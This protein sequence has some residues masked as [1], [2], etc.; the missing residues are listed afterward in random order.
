MKIFIINN[1]YL[2]M[3]RQW[4]QMF[5]GK[6]YSQV[7]LEVQPD[8][9]RLAEAFGTVGLS[10]GE[11]GAPVSL[12]AF[13]SP[14]AGAAAEHRGRRAGRSGRSRWL[15]PRRRR[16]RRP[17]RRVSRRRLAVFRPTGVPRRRAPRSSISS[18]RSGT[19]HAAC[20]RVLIAIATMP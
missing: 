17:A 11:N 15:K 9:V 1:K 2:G 18:R 6:R 19:R 3:V 12:A 10:M 8:F 7:D 16:R 5:Y 14:A 13:F 4:Q 20:G